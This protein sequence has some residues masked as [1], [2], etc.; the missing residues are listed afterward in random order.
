MATHTQWTLD[1]IERRLPQLVE[2]ATGI[3]ADQIQPSDRLIEDLH[4]D[5]I[6]MLDLIFRVEREIDVKF[7]RGKSMFLRVPFRVSDIAEGVYLLQQERTVQSSSPNS[8]PSETPSAPCVPFTQLGARWHGM[9][10]SPAYEPWDLEQKYPQ[11][12]R[13]RDGMR[14]ILLPAATVEVGSNLPESDDD[15]RPLHSVRLD[16]FLIDAETVSTTAYCR[17]LNSIGNVGND[18][19]RD[20]CLLAANDRRRRHEVI[21]QTAGHWQPAPGAAAWPMML[22]SWYGA[23]AYSLWVHGR[24][25]RGYRDETAA[26]PGSFL[27]SEA[28]WEYASRGAASQRYPWGND[29]SPSQLRANLYSPAASQNL[30]G[31]PLGPVNELL[32]MS[33][34]GLHHAA[35][36]V[37]QWCRDWYDPNFYATQAARQPNAVNRTAGDARSE[38][39]SSWVGPLELCRSSYRRGRSP[40]A[41]GR[42]LGFRCAAPRSELASEE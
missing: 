14:C 32:G 42:C 4:C 28:Q 10:E 9:P 35:G 26:G 37:W 5:S 27:P 8:V 33:P 41:R 20:W 30:A 24:D 7:D 6:G 40:R 39:G 19:L 12:R 36:N 2:A 3:E 18:V 29:A 23:N 21:E 38:R 17:F 11:Y 1:E 16:A 13:R 34:L 15:E 25:W 31:L 22:V